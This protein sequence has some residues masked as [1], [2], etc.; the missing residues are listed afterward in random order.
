MWASEGRRRWALFALLAVSLLALWWAWL[1]FWFL[2]DDAYITFR[3]ISNRHLGLGYVWN[4]PPFRAVEGYSN[5]LWM[6]LL[7]AVWSV[8]GVDPPRAANV[9]SLLCAGLSTWRVWRWS[10]TSA[11]PLWRTALALLFLLGN[12]TFLTWSSSGLETALFNLL[13]LVW[14]EQAWRAHPRRGTAGFAWLALW[15]S[16]AALTRPDGLLAWAATLFLGALPPLAAGS[17]RRHLA[18]GAALS[19][20]PLHFLWRRFT[21]GE[22][23][24]NTYYAKHV[25]P[26]PDAGVRYLGC[27]LVEY[28]YWALA[29]LALVMAVRWAKQRPPLEVFRFVAA[30]TLVAHALYYVIRV[31]GDHFEYRVLSQWVP[32]L[33]LGWAFLLSEI[34]RLWLRVVAIALSLLA[35]MPVQWAHYAHSRPLTTRHQTWKLKVPVAPM[36]GPIFRPLA[37]W[38]DAQQS[39]LI[40]HHVCMRHQEHKVFGE[41]QRSTNPERRTVDVRPEALP[42]IALATVGV[43]G[44]VFPNVAIIDVFGLNDAVVAR[45]PVASEHFRLMAHDRSPPLGYV[46]CFRPNVELHGQGAAQ[47][48]ARAEPPSPADV[49]ACERDFLAIVKGTQE[50]LPS[51]TSDVALTPAQPLTLDEFEALARAPD[52][53]RKETFDAPNPS[54]ETKGLAFGDGPTSR[55]LPQQQAIGR[56]SGSYLNSFH[57]GDLSTG[58]VSFP[59]PA[60]TRRVA[61]KVAGGGAC[62]SLFAGVVQGSR[63]L[64]KACGSQSE[65]LQAVLLTVAGGAELRFVA[66]DGSS[67][68]WG[69][70]IVDDVVALGASVQ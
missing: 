47:V 14:F 3:Y 1:E 23:L 29:V 6:L 43:P 35:A 67:E 18:A 15:A 12:R 42:V 17:W 8:A 7:D 58:M 50:A 36:L 41:E 30:G 13:L 26:W 2:T 20:V 68:G 24:P 19:L 28:G 31:G 46:D 48:H 32:V 60:G 59:L 40:E 27:F 57:R 64:A 62:G 10:S 21:Y 56:V 54:L 22:W 49:R 37:E 69:H 61:L 16:L 52:V 63:L 66:F 45:H 33:A 51:F 65:E 9:L 70:L 34:S 11:S 55:T 39:W 44:W 38:F 4:A 53:L 25:A 5:F